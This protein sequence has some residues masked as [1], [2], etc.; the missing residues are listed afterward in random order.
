MTAKTVALGNCKFEILA[1]NDLFIGL[2]KIRIGNTLVRSGRLPLRPYTQTFT[3]LELDAL[4]LLG[5]DEKPGEIRVKLEARFSPLPVK[6]MRDHSFDPIHETGDWDKPVA[7]GSGQLDIVLRPAADSFNGTGF[8]GFSYCYDYRSENVPLFYILDKAS[9]ELDGDVLGATAYSQSSCSAPVATFAKDTAWTTEGVLWF[10]AE[11]A[12]ENP[13]MTHNLPRWASHGSF[14]FQFKGGTTLIG[15]F[16]RVDLIRSIICRDAG[17]PELKTFDKHIFDQALSY[18]TAAKSIMINS[19]AKTVVGQQNLWTWV[20]DEVDRRARAEFGIK[21]EPV[22]PALGQNFWDNFMVDS[23]YKDLLPAASAIG[24]RWIFVDNL[25]KS[26]MTERAPLPGVFNWNMCCNHEYEISDRLGGVKRVKDFTDICRRNNVQVMEW[27]NNDQALSSPI[28]A[29]ERDD[30]GWFVRLE[31]CRLKYGGAYAGVFSVLD[32]AEPAARQYFVDS[33]IKVKEQTGIDALFF[34]SFYNLGFMPINY[35]YRRP[36]TMW[37]GLLQ[38]FRELQEAGCNMAIES[39]GPFG[40][41]Q[42]GHPSS[43]CMDTVFA[44]Y[45]VGLGNDYTTVPTTNPMFKGTPDSPTADFFCLAHK[46]G[47]ASMYLFKDGRRI[48]EIWTDSQKRQLAVYHQVL[49]DLCT[50]YLQDDGKS[51]VWHN[52]DGSKA[53]VWNFV[54]RD[55]ALPGTVVDL[56]DGKDLPKSGKYR[57]QAQHVY[58]ITGGQVPTAVGT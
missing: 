52:A 4:R 3:G 40:L 30:K 43:Y 25:K 49:H 31:D 27:T 53:T 7:A 56:T 18:R 48:D 20:Y 2:G 24:I 42:H 11:Q 10:L 34:D 38:A 19:D 35:R 8:R 28:N 51:V 1:E 44:C 46:A 9:W 50:R 6:L 47:L 33:H 37:R 57:L 58:A 22:I 21:D 23:Y 5:I 39:F 32:M 13:V 29:A 36:R 26:C 55:A 16:E 14:D 17:K 41:P 12:N 54:D 45:R 15:V